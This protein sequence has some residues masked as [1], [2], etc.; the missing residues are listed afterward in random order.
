MYVYDY[1]S[2]NEIVRLVY[3]TFI[4]SFCRIAFY[5]YVQLFSL[6]VFPIRSGICIFIARILAVAVTGRYYMHVS[7]LIVAWSLEEML[8]D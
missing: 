6:F 3:D 5:I 8:T 2:V 1:E 4:M 7:S